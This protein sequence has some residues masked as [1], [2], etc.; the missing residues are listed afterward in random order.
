MTTRATG[1][2]SRPL[3]FGPRRA[4]YIPVTEELHAGRIP[5]TEPGAELISDLER[6]DLL[7]RTLCGVLYNFVPTSGHPGG[8][9]SSG[10][11]VSSLLFT[12]LDYDFSNPDEPT[13]DFLVY[14]AGHKA[15][16]LYA[17]WA[18]RNEIVR[19]GAPELLPREERMQ[20][21]LEDLLGFRRNPTTKTPLFCEHHAKSLDGHPTPGTPGVKISTGA[22]GVGVPSGLGL[23]MG[24]LD[25][26]GPQ[27]AP[28]VH[29]IEGEGGMTPG[30]VS[31]ALATAATAGLRNA[32]LHVDWNQASIDSDRVCR[33]GK[34]PGDYVQWDPIEMA[35]LHDWNV[36]Q[37]DDGHD[38]KQILAAME[39]I[40]TQ[41]NDQPTAVVYRTDKGWRYWI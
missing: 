30:R 10:R 19:A 11:I 41:P 29:L 16:G 9:I 33:D 39:L 13:N 7:Y 22:S 4:V 17:M 24:A 18:L 23:A 12:L 36:Y 21:R 2:E 35:Y 15:M 38:W 6:Y 34:T 37:V 5:G 31:E 27:D 1:P 8:S 3:P 28:H 25:T 32:F 20:L 40:R 26:F 14:A